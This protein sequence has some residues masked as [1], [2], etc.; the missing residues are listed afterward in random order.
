MRSKL[1]LLLILALPGSAR[2]QAGPP[3]S[4]TDGVRSAA[5]FTVTGG[6]LAGTTGAHIGGWGGL[7]F[8]DRFLLGGGGFAITKNVELPGLDDLRMG[9]GGI[10][11]RYWG[12][13]SRELTWGVGA[14]LG[15][16][17]ARIRNRVV[18]T[19]LGSDNFVLAE[20]SLSLAHPLIRS[21]H[22]EVALGYRKAWGVEDL[23]T[24]SA[25]DLTSL[26]GSISLRL[27]GM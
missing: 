18:G 20:P 17:N 25:D 12:T 24:L 2:A 9:Y 8:G 11:V 4:T 5:A 14:L 27:G 13:V 23:P 16:G 21:L 7:V 15:A 19:E 22:L 3:P 26:T 10:V 6:K 1:P